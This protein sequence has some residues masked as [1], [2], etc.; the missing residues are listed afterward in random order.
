MRYSR[1]SDLVDTK[2]FCTP[3]NVIGCGAVGSFV[4]LSLA[5]MGFADITVWDSDLIDEENISNQF[6]PLKMVGINKAEAL[7]ELIG[8]FEDIKITCIPKNWKGEQLKGLVLSCVDGMKVRSQL[9]NHVTRCKKVVGFIDA[10]MGGY[11]AEIYT[12]NPHLKEDKGIYRKNL[13]TDD[14][15]T[16]IPCTQKAVI[17]N[18]LTLCGILVNMVRIY[19]SGQEYSR[20]LWLDLANNDIH[21]PNFM[22]KKIEREAASLPLGVEKIRVD[23]TNTRIEV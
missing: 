11:Q 16:T 17:F 6:Y 14:M 8:K 20:V 1:Q 15:A 7:G 12:I 3:L 18:V 9:F 13:Y 22:D 21:K 5:K 19:L 23:L 10:R 4:V 2:I